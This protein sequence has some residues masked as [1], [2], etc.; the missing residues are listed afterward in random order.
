M[1]VGLLCSIRRADRDVS[2]Q[3]EK[4]IIGCKVNVKEHCCVQVYLNLEKH[5]L[6]CVANGKVQEKFDLS[7][8]SS[9]FPLIKYDGDAHLTAKVIV[10]A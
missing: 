8:Y 3:E 4:V 6:L 7:Q 10:A 2:D 9:C 5:I 1:T